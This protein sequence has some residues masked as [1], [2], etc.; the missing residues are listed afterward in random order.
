METILSS[1]NAHKP[2]I[3]GAILKKGLLCTALMPNGA[4]MLVNYAAKENPP[5]PAAKQAQFS[6]AQV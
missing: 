6:S 2:S 1:P 3:T 5:I 4:I